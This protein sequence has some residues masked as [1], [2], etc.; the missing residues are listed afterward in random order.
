[1]CENLHALIFTFVGPWPDRPIKLR[2]DFRRQ[3]LTILVT[4]SSVNN[5][6]DGSVHY[7]Q[8]DSEPIVVWAYG[9]RNDGV[10]LL[11]I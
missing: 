11:G 1:M 8:N 6:V 5:I 4:V 3:Q 10:T 9:G 2:I 7:I